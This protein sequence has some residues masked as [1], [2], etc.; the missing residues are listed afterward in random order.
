MAYYKPHAAHG[1][2]VRLLVPRWWGYKSVKWLVRLT[3]TDKNYLGYWE[4]L[5]YPDVAKIEGG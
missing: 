5:G 1:Y 3:V 2:P 4:S